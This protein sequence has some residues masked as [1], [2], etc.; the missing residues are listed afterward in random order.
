MAGKAER[1]STRPGRRAAVVS[2]GLLLIAALAG[3]AAGCGDGDDAEAAPSRSSRPSTSAPAASDADTSSTT[4]PAPPS[5]EASTVPDE[6][7]AEPPVVVIDPGHNGANGAHPGEI[8]DLVDAGGFQKACNTVGSSTDGGYTESAF[9]LAV[10][11]QLRDRLAEADVEVI[12]TRSDDEGWGPCVDQ[13]GQVAALNG[14]AMLV[15]IHADGAPPWATGFHVI[16]PG[17]RVGYTEDTAGPSRELATLVRDELVA[18]GLSPSDYVGEGGIHE[19]TDLGTLNRAEV[20]AV[21]L[22]AG[23]MRNDG[24]ADM[25]VSPEGQG[26]IA[27]A[28]AAAVLGFLPR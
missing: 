8:N 1:S 25:L 2:R 11:L 26:R 24:E 19:R 28:L 7:P 13:R 21:M 12:L 5:T 10:A 15:S 27:D 17:I 20:P 14:A 3:A 23:N 6:P 22:E 4:G 16:H 18:G 9:N